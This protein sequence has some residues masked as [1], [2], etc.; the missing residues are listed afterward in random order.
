MTDPVALQHGCAEFRR[1]PTINRRGFLKIGALG[2]ASLSLASLLQ[3]EAAA[4]PAAKRDRSVI[5]LWMAGGPS[6]V[7]M[8]DPKPNAPVE[9]RGEFGTIGT[10]VPGIQLCELLPMSAR[11]MN[12]WSIV[13]SLHHRAEDGPADHG[14]GDQIC[15]TGYPAAPKADVMTLEMAYPSCGVIVAEQLGSRRPELPANVVIPRMIPGTNS[16]YLGAACKPFETGADPADAGPF[17]VRNLHATPE[18]T[19]RRLGDRKQ[20]LGDLDSLRGRLDADGQMKAWSRFE[21]QAMDMLSSDAAQRAFDLDAEPRAVRERYG[22]MSPFVRRPGT[23]CS[24]APAWSQRVLLARRLVEAGVRL[25]T[26]DMRSW[27]TH[28]ANFDAMRRGHLPPFDKVYSALIEDLDQR[29]LL[30]STLVIAWGEMGRSPRVN[31]SAGRDHWPSAFNAAL[32]GGR[33]QGGRVVGSTD[34][35]GARPKDMSKTPQDVLATL[36]NHLGIDTNKH[37]LDNSGRPIRVLPCGE[38]IRELF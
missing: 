13:R 22:F 1:R 8:W 11:I 5:I 36:Y 19:V 26:V 2:T 33:V 20:L 17:N 37:Y 14:S 38:P 10:S 35:I 6:H 18:L 34:S 28:Q 21:H 30:N 25:V 16:A 9:V 24:T 12:K 32:A 27:D 4:G 3:H 29:G 15:F 23:C 7:D 31:N